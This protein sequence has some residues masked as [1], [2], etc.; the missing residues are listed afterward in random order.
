[1]WREAYLETRILSAD[2][3]ELVCLLYQHAI[4]AVRDARRHLATGDIAARAQAMS[5]AL[6]ILG[7]LNSSLNHGAGG[8]LS[9]N[10]E[11]LYGYMMTRLTE[12]NL[13]K[14]DKA[15]AEVEKLLS[16]LAEAWTAVHALQSKTAQPPAPAWQDAGGE[17][18]AAHMWSA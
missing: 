12:G 6:A 2:P 18:P 7:E 17:S 11:Q 13:Q 8:A 5:K 3:M 10:L 1:M 4:D 14:D 9:R 15:L 16:S